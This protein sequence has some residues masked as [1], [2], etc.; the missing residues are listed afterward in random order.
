MH[1]FTDNYIKVTCGY[2]PLLIN[3]IVPTELSHI[4]DDGTVHGIDV[5]AGVQVH[6]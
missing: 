5:T 2:D 1:G 6:H 3:E 4:L